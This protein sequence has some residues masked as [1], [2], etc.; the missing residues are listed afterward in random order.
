MELPMDLIPLEGGFS[1]ET[2]VTG[3][4]GEQVV[5]RIHA[6]RSRARGPAAVDIDAA[7]LRLMRGIVPVPQVLEVRRPTGELPGLLVTEFLAGER[8]DHLLP[9]LDRE[10]LAQVGANLGALVD[11]LTHVPT[12]RAGP[13][14]DETLRIGDDLG[15]DG[16]PGWVE[17]QLPALS[18]WNASLRTRLI[19]LAESAQD[20]LDTVDRTCLVHGD[21]N[22]KNLLIDPATLQVTGVLDWEFAR[23]GSPY[24]DLGNLLR[25][26]RDEDFVAGVLRGLGS[27]ESRSDLLDLGRAADLV[28]LVDLAVRDHDPEGRNP[29]TSAAQALLL[30]LASHGLPTGCLD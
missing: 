21:L 1:G 3:A 4:P 13:F 12:L 28:A 9:M 15:P 26:E 10:S 16:L 23:S 14:V 30:D 22:L 19:R 17:A 11:R 6:G 20:L 8:A 7:V 27:A 25:F 18:T 2:F 5:V 24:S 29:V